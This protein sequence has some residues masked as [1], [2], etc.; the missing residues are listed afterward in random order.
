MHCTLVSIFR[1]AYL[2]QAAQQ[3]SFAR[4]AEKKEAYEEAFG[5]Y[6]A[7]INTLLQGVQGIRHKGYTL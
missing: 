7:A 3:I 1:G 2:S 6:K 4:T 5:H